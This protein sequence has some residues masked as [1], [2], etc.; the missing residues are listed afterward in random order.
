MNPLNLFPEIIIGTA[1]FGMRYGVTGDAKVASDSELEDILDLARFHGISGIDTAQEYGNA[2]ERLGDFDLACFKIVSKI[3]MPTSGSGLRHFDVRSPLVLSLKKLNVPSID[4]LLVHN[5][6]GLK[7]PVLHEALK[8]LRSLKDDGLV[9]NLGVSLYTPDVLRSARILEEIDVVQAPYN[10]FDQRIAEPNI[11]RLCARAGV[12]ISVRS[13]F[14]QGTLLSYNS[15]LP[16]FFDTW[17]KQFCLWDEWLKKN[18]ISALE[19]SLNQVS[20]M[21]QH[22][23]SSFVV[24]VRSANELREILSVYSKAN[25]KLCFD[26]SSKDPKLITPYMWPNS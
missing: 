9:K 7:E 4:T 16:S 6:H 21:L 11:L 14:L 17:Q 2:K 15:G 18:S 8:K 25:A 13:I 23:A 3:N 20:K 1:Q 5:A 22:G 19:G 26:G 24:G 12:E 10:A